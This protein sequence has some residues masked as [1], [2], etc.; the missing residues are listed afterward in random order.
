MSSIRKFF[1]P[2]LGLAKKEAEIRVGQ[3]RVI[4]QRI[5]MMIVMMRQHHEDDGDYLGNDHDVDDYHDDDLG[6]TK[7]RQE[8]GSVG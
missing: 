1:A 7:K 5:V 6:L 8:S 3:V 4:I 2:V